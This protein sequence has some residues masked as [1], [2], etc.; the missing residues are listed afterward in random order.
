MSLGITKYNS[1]LFCRR[2]AFLLLSADRAC[3]SG[4]LERRLFLTHA[5][6]AWCG[7]GKPSHASEAVDGLAVDYETEV[8]ATRA[9]ATGSIPVGGCHTPFWSSQMP[10]ER[11]QYVISD[12]NGNVKYDG[13]KFDTAA[14]AWN[15]L[16][17]DQ[18]KRHPGASDFEIGQI[19]AE[20]YIDKMH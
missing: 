17:Q 1:R 7:L 10:D 15:F 5:S 8:G 2:V 11:S 6:A 12:W 3:C 14:D 13:Q 20:F 9:G 18:R 4:K 19:I 16:I